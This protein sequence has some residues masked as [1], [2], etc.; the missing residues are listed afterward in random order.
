M[1]REAESMG[2]GPFGL[3]AS[4]LRL[5]MYPWNTMGS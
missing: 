1:I 2:N 3:L 4:G 5:V